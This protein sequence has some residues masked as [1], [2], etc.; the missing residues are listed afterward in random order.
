M[1]TKNLFGTLLFSSLL[2]ISCKEELKPQED[3]DV[4]V[5]AVSE[6]DNSMNA[7]TAAPNAPATNAAQQPTNVA[8]GMN[9]PHGQPNHRCDI[10]VGA[11]LNSPAKP[12]ATQPAANPAM[13]VSSTPAPAAPK[14]VNTAPVV[15]AP[16]MNP[17][18]GQ[19]GH[20]C[21]IAVGAP[22]PK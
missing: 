18:H 21:E 16:G 17:P 5:V 12:A 1:T 14:P 22:L 6:T 7:T 19:A 9:P 2:L 13:N 20:L 15:T 11:P 10:E 8:P 4:P 3:S